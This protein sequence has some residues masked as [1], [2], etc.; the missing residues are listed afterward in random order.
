[1]VLP[2]T[3]S[4][5]TV[6]SFC[7]R[8]PVLSDADDGCAAQRLDGRQAADQRVLLR[9]LAH[10]DREV[11]RDDRGQPFRHGCHSQCHRNQE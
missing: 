10:A 7:V 9:H 5:V 11:D 6:I 8:V 1:M 4:L 2:S 3:E